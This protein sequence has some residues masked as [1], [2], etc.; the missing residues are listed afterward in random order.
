MPEHVIKFIKDG[1][2]S[3]VTYLLKFYNVKNIAYLR[4]SDAENLV[5]KGL[6][7]RQRA[8]ENEVKRPNKWNN[9]EMPRYQTKM[10][11]PILFAIYF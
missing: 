1:D 10:W 11:N 8:M 4:F 6:N 3:K 5:I 7:Y 2:K 9:V